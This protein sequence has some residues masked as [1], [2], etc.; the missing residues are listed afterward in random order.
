LERP[1]GLRHPLSKQ[2]WMAKVLESLR[3]KKRIMEKRIY[4]AHAKTKTCTSSQVS[5][6]IVCT[7][8]KIWVWPCAKLTTRSRKT[9]SEFEGKAQRFAEQRIKIVKQNIPY[10][11]R[12]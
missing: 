3:K 9:Q 4:P 10:Q 12:A 11:N 5:P 7:T 6:R 1:T 2:N 8:K